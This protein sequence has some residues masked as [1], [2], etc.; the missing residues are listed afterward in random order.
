LATW[1]D[2]CLNNL[3]LTYLHLDDNIFARL[4]AEKVEQPGFLEGLERFEQLKPQLEEMLG[5]LLAHQV[6][7]LTDLWASPSLLSLESSIRSYK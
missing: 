1:A 3:I 7:P 5:W 6:R 4:C 2:L